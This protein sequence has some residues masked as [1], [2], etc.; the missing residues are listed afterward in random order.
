MPRL[1]LPHRAEVRRMTE[2]PK[3][4]LGAPTQVWAS[5]AGAEAVPCFVQQ[6]DARE[7]RTEVGE[8]VIVNQL[9]FAG[10]NPPWGMADRLVANGKTIHV[11]DLDPDVAARGHHSETVGHVVGSA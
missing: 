1:K 10:P 4:R 2:G 5:V 6:T 8:V 11:D 3:G 7:Y 9:L